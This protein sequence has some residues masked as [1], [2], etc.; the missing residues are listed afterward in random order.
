[1]DL[2]FHESEDRLELYA[3]GRL[4]DSEIEQV[5]E[6]LMVCEPCREL[7]EQTS[8]S[9]LA[10]REELSKPVIHRP[11]FEGWFGWLTPRVMSAAAFAVF[12]LA[13]ILY[14]GGESRLAPVASLQLTAM[15]GGMQS[16]GIARETDLVLTDAPAA[17][18]PLSVEVVDGSGTAVWN[19]TGNN[20]GRGVELKIANRLSPGDYFVR[21]RSAKGELLH[22]YGFRVRK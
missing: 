11:A 22:E 10:F 19:G 16:V 4:G 6:H 3:L 18:T 1:M 8:V 21:L 20:S 17:G 2:T 5:E 12:V 15:R 9:A 14:W 13:A 7:L